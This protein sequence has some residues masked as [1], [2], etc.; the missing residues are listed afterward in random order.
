MKRMLLSMTILTTLI[1]SAPAMAGER[2]ELCAAFATWR[3]AL[4]SGKAENVVQL[5]NSDAVL[6]ATLADEPIINQKERTA[7]FTK[8]TAK[9]NLKATVNKEFIRVLDEDDA[10]ISGVYTFSFD[11]NGKSVSIP[12]RYTFV[13]EKQY[14]EWRIVEHH[15]SKLP[16]LK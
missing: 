14:G 2:D 8:L 10:V 15:S 5:Y 13:Y 12:A 11:E 16:S 4:S 6:L 1:A 9:K 7:Y 3:E